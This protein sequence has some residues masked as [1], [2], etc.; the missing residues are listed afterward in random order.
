[1]AVFAQLYQGDAY[2]WDDDYIIPTTQVN[3]V[4]NPLYVTPVMAAFV[5]LA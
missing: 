5:N 3:N 4:D 1:M 2:S